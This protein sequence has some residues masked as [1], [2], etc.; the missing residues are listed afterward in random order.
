MDG[1]AELHAASHATSEPR[2]W[3]IGRSNC[4]DLRLVFPEHYQLPAIVASPRQCMS[5]ELIKD[6]FKCRRRSSRRRDSFQWF[7]PSRRICQ[8]RVNGII[9]R[10][11][12]IDDTIHMLGYL[13][14]LHPLRPS[15][16]KSKLLSKPNTSVEQG[17]RNRRSPFR[18]PNTTPTPR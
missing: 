12:I 1:V 11:G 5:I 8:D 14:P 13:W 3:I 16:S 10:Q 15:I 2:T 7:R 6:L 17:E 18:Q 9:V 4:L